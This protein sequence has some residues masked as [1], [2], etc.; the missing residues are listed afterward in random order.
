MPWKRSGGIGTYEGESVNRS[1]I[2]IKRTIC[3]IRTWEKRLF[4]DISFTNSD[5]STLVPS[6]YQCVKTRSI[7]VFCLLSQPVSPFHRLRLWNVLQRIS[8][9]SCEPLYATNTSLRK[10]ETFL[11]EYPSHWV[12]LLIKTHKRTLLFG[13]T[14]LKHGRHF[15]YWKQTLNMRMRVCFLDY[16]EGGLCCYLVIHIKTYYVHYRCFT[17]ICDLFTDFSYLHVLLTSALDT[18]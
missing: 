14:H 11:Y 1:Q 2:D 3:D 6:L 10:Q 18:S 16:R 12:L 4:L 7:E 8:R 9:P 17:S 15:D 5:T 13:I